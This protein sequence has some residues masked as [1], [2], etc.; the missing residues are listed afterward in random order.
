MSEATDKTSEYDQEL[1][2]RFGTGP[3]DKVK[4]DDNSSQKK[5]SLS[6]AD[7]ENE[8]RLGSDTADSDHVR[9]N[10]YRFFLRHQKVYW[11][12]FSLRRNRLI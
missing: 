5:D 8:Q 4:F 10:F 11:N 12:I 9:E 2:R 1:R 3:D 7:S 6:P